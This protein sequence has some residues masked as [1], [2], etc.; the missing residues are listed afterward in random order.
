VLSG[1]GAE[2]IER[3]RVSAY[4][5]ATRPD[6]ADDRFR[7]PFRLQGALWVRDSNPHRELV[8]RAID[9]LREQAALGSLPY[10][11]MQIGRDAA[12][13]DRWDDAEATYLE[14]IRLARETGQ[15]TDLAASLTGLA[16]LYARQ[17]RGDECRRA[18]RDADPLSTANQIRL[19]SVWQRFALGDLASGAGIQTEAARCYESLEE[20]LRSRGLA[21]PDQS[22]AP[23]LVETYVH[24][25]RVA[26]AE[27]VAHRFEVQAR[28]KGQPWS[29]ARAERALAVSGPARSAEQRFRA[30]LDLHAVTPD[31]YETARTELAFGAHLRRDRRRVEARPLLRS[32]L[33]TFEG[34]GARPWADRA[35]QELHATG[36]TV[37]RRQGDRQDDLTPQERQVAQ[38]LAQGRTTR[39][40]AAALFLSP[41]TVEYHLRHVYLKLDI[42]SRAELAERFGQR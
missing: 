22:C 12:T 42:R 27:Q 4:E 29:L 19:A 2:G 7:L 16:C 17:G 10:V 3:L 41:K 11:L 9:R 21:D 14:S 18:L 5:L 38:M 24:V 36:E 33:A 40:A 28:A 34:L 6:A 37:R 13:S 39:E 30:A 26:D 23:E 35:A 15:T 25:G 8:A 31:R 1:K 20:L 32:A